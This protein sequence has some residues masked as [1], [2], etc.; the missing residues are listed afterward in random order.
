MKKWSEVQQA[1]LDKL[2]MELKEAKTLKYEKKF[3][4]LANEC[5]NMIANR[6]KPNVCRFEFDVVNTE[7]N[8]TNFRIENGVVHY[9]DTFGA[10]QTLTPDRKVVYVDNGVS[11][12]WRDNELKLLSDIDD[13]FKCG[14]FIK[15]PDN[16][17][18][19]ADIVN[20]KDGVPD[21]VI[22][23]VTDNTIKIDVPG[24]YSIFYNGEWET[25]RGEYGANDVLNI[26]SS[27]LNCLPTYIASQVLAQDDIQRSSILKNEFELLLAGLD[28]NAM[29]ETN[30]YKSTGGWY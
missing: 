14:D 24:K 4:Y 12:V 28:T 17:I 15:M 26:D 2:F 10:E 5:L 20:Y 6:V 30:H 29:Y 23:Y 1:T 9:T 25:I 19:F 21:P 13:V 22:T 11:Y 16:F 3:A 7:V 8:G 27:V 18:S